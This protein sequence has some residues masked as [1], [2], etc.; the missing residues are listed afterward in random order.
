MQFSCIIKLT[1]VAGPTGCLGASVSCTPSGSAPSLSGLTTSCHS[2]SSFGALVVIPDSFS[3]P[4]NHPVGG[5]TVPSSSLPGSQGHPVLSSTS[6]HLLILD[7]H[8]CLR[9]FRISRVWAICLGHNGQTVVEQVDWPNC[10]LTPVSH[11]RSKMHTSW[12]QSNS[13]R[14]NMHV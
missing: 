1:D 10:Q 8:Q 5:S 11:S 4:T 9:M 3:G 12:D 2:S 14:K 6:L 7:L 13:K